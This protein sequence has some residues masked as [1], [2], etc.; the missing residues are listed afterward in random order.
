M[1]GP[2]ELRL[3][4]IVTLRQIFH[5]LVHR[6]L[7]P[8]GQRGSRYCQNEQKKN[9]GVLSHSNLWCRLD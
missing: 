7:T 3:D 9:D 8:A 2:V 4:F 5:L 6:G 1:N